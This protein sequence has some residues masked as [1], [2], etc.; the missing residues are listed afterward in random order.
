MKSLFDAG[1]QQGCNGIL[2]QETPA[3]LENLKHQN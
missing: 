2:W 1:F 3:W